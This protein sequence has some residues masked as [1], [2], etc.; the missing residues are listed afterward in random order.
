MCFVGTIITNNVFSAPGFAPVMDDNRQRAERLA[1]SVGHLRLPRQ[2]PPLRLRA[3]SYISSL[4][5][6]KIY[7]YRIC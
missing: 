7:M 6:E 1:A 2:G 5:G 4:L 3:V